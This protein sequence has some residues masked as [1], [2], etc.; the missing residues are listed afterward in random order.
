M[1][2]TPRFRLLTPEE[3][4]DIPEDQLE[5]ESRLFDWLDRLDR[6]ESGMLEPSHHALQIGP[7]HP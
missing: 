7:H 4:A 3:V 1:A 5:A 6:A 2:G